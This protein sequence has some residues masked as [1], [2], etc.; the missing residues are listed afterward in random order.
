VTCIDN[1]GDFT[2]RSAVTPRVPSHPRVAPIIARDVRKRRGDSF[3]G[4]PPSLPVPP[5]PARPGVGR[6][7]GGAKSGRH[8]TRVPH[9]CSGQR[10]GSSRGLIEPLGPRGVQH[11]GSTGVFR[12]RDG[13]RPQEPGFSS[14]RGAETDQRQIGDGSNRRPVSLVCSSRIPPGQ[15]SRD[16]SRL[17]AQGGWFSPTPLARVANDDPALSAGP[18]KVVMWSYPII[19]NGLV[20][21]RR[22]GQT[23][24]A[25]H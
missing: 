6:S 5:C 18:N 7:E 22:R 19:R 25:T 12:V 3:R 8:P 23:C 9:L 16:R 10:R 13:R 15:T 11:V 21:P 4:H 24:Y 20:Y 17:P 14:R 2:G 1:A